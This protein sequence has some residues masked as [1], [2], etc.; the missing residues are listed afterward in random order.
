VFTFST[1]EEETRVMREQEGDMVREV[2]LHLT[3]EAAS[4]QVLREFKW[5]GGE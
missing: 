2:P 5:L 4:L 1:N 3:G